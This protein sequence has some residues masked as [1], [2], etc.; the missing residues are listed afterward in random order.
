MQGL[1]SL[2]NNTC[3]VF[4]GHWCRCEHARVWLKKSCDCVIAVG[5]RAVEEVQPWR[6]GSGGAILLPVRPPR[7]P[8][9]RSDSTH[10]CRFCCLSEAHTSG[11][12]RTRAP[13]P[14]RRSCAGTLHFHS[15][16]SLVTHTYEHMGREVKRHI[17]G[18]SSHTGA[19]PC[20]P[21]PQA[22]IYGEMA[23]CRRG[24]FTPQELFLEP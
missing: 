1:R 14:C 9:P 2:W 10:R 15:Y 19:E 7:S 20:K 16:K 13:R 24:A 22:D 3:L 17:H 12:S 4:L 8:R 5:R 18:L 23:L 6:Q 11:G 21:Q